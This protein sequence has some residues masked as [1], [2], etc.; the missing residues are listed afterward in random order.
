MTKP[1]PT[2]CTTIT[3]V[4]DGYPVLLPTLASTEAELRR[5]LHEDPLLH[6][7][8]KSTKG[9]TSGNDSFDDRTYLQVTLPLEHAC[10]S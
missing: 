10:P 3:L 9:H 6:T 8:H 4:S 5:V 1:V 2:G 7:L